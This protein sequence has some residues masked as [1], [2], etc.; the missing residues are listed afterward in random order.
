MMNSTER[1]NESNISK[2]EY[3]FNVTSTKQ[4]WL[5]W[6]SHLIASKIALEFPTSILSIVFDFAKQ[7]RRCVFISSIKTNDQLSNLNIGDIIL[8]D[9]LK[10]LIFDEKCQKYKTVG[11]FRS[12]FNTNA[13]RKSEILIPY[14]T[15]TSNK[16][17]AINCFNN[18][19]SVYSDII[20]SNDM[21]DDNFNS[22]K[23]RCDKYDD[24]I[25]YYLLPNNVRLTQK[26]FANVKVKYGD[27]DDDDEKGNSNINVN[28]DENMLT[29]RKYCHGLF[30]K[31]PDCWR[32]EIQF[33]E[34]ILMQ[35]VQVTFNGF[36][37]AEKVY[38]IYASE[39]A[40][41]PKFKDKQRYWTFEEL[42]KCYHKSGQTNKGC[43]C[44]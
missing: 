26:D 40:K 35:I 4:A 13:E 7:D 31:I 23:I 18:V 33:C 43:V 16:I 27:D 22:I 24:F 34:Q 11:L 44:R 5:E 3:S 32:F 10:H 21:I 9:I 15:V 17:F 28:D 20:Y 12:H 25:K 37:N 2:I 14:E 8:D 41:N 29:F 38:L 42:L 36:K 1:L 6:L 30:V 39:Q 19:T